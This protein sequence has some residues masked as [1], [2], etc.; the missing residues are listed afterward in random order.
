MARCYDESDTNFVRYGARGI[1]VCERWHDFACFW[2][3]LQSWESSNLTL[4]RQNNDG[5]YSPENCIFAP[6]AVQAR[7]TRSNVY[8]EYNGR[9]MVIQDWAKEFGISHN[10]LTY[11]IRAGWSIERALYTPTGR[12]KRGKLIEFDG[13]KKSL[14]DW[15]RTMDI[16][17]DTIR[18]R[19]NAGWSAERALTTPVLR[20]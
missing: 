7:N 10:T 12:T 19:L 11:R 16:Q 3:D 15:S 8:L 14:A 9:R 13:Q 6:M 1:F 5:P 2:S 20:N 4:E 17:E 18:A